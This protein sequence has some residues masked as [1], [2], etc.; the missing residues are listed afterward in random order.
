M[1]TVGY[2]TEIDI[3]SAQVSRLA[4][5]LKN[6]RKRLL[7]L[8]E[9]LDAWLTRTGEPAVRHNGKVIYKM[10]KEKPSRLT[11]Q[12]KD[13]NSLEYLQSIGI[14]D[15]K[16]VLEKL[17]EVQKGEV[18]EIT[19]VCIDDE[20]TYEKKMEKEKKKRTKKNSHRR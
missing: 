20:K 16:Y 7:E 12:E 1:D 6:K 19:Q 8:R 5:E 4:S 9:A 10:T 2:A 3:L 14:S 11:K 15:P 13:A 17:K 18:E